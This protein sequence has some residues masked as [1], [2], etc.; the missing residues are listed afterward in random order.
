ML[1]VSPLPDA[2]PS[3]LLFFASASDPMPVSLRKDSV[4]GQWLGIGEITHQSIGDWVTLGA[5]VSVVQV[6]PTNP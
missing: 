3:R 2:S 4:N 6:L 5:F 1:P